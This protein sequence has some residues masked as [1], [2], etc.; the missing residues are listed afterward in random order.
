MAGR[1]GQRAG[2]P[3]PCA[4]PYSRF[5]N[6]AWIASGP[7]SPIHRVKAHAAVTDVDLQ[8]VPIVLQFVHP[9]ITARW[10]NSDGRTAGLGEGSRRVYWPAA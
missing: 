10:L 7:I 5:L 3:G 4:T 2:H 9:A 8:P 6:D 1:R